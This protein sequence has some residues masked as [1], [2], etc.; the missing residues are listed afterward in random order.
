MIELSLVR[1]TADGGM[2]RR[3]DIGMQGRRK[4]VKK[5]A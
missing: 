1:K 2:H 4:E 3:P 5:A